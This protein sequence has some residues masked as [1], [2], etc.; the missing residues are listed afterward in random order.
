MEN[1]TYRA[2]LANP[3]I[4]EEI[5]RQARHARAEAVH[6]YLAAPLARTVRRIR[7]RA[8]GRDF[9]PP[10]CCLPTERPGLARS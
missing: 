9:C 5:E 3:A 6:Q 1:L 10:E 4:G 8:R 2:Y 7:A